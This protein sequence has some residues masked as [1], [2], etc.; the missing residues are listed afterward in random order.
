MAE[1]TYYK[2]DN[3]EGMGPEK[4]NINTEFYEMSLEGPTIFINKTNVDDLSHSSTL[5]LLSSWEIGNMI[6]NTEI[7]RTDTATANKALKDKINNLLTTTNSFKENGNLQSIYFH[8]KIWN[9]KQGVFQI[10]FSRFFLG[11]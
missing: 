10:Y 2:I 6:A 9:H 4:F 1:V 11:G 3:N 5:A 7:N 8:L